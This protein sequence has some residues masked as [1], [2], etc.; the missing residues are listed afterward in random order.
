MFMDVSGRGGDEERR[1]I[2]FK[3]ALTLF[4]F[5]S[6]RWPAIC[7][8]L[9]GSLTT[10]IASGVENTLH[11]HFWPLSVPCVILPGYKHL[12]KKKKPGELPLKYS[13]YPPGVVSTLTTLVGWL[14]GWGHEA[15]RLNKYE[16]RRGTFLS[17]NQTPRRVTREIRLGRLNDIF[18]CKGVLLSSL[19]AD[20]VSLNIVA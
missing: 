7:S 5:G 18:L 15:R 1:S 2:L 3:R 20:L 12:G 8:A 17:K 14:I 19:R 11:G 13:L 4:A 9:V 6:P 16:S 10:V